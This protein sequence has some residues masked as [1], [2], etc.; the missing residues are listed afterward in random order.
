MYA[1]EKRIYISADK[2]RADV[3]EVVAGRRTESHYDVDGNTKRWGYKDIYEMMKESIADFSSHKV[4][5][6]GA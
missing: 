6:L 3:V 5:Q 1:N 4:I 2:K